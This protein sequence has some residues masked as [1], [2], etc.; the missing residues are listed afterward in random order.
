[1]T[2]QGNNPA[3]S[4]PA[5]ASFVNS[6]YPTSFNG[7]SVSIGGP[8]AYLYCLSTGQLNVISPGN[9]PPG[10]TQVVVTNNGVASEP[11]TVSV[12]P[13][14]PAF[15]LWPGGYAVARDQNFQLRVKAGKFSG[16][17]TTPAT[18][19]TIKK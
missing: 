17:M 6:S 15:F 19:L 1:M 9:L 7:V 16:V 11:A 4:Q 14:A 10:N 8:P 12:Q 2:I 13:F 18:M 5:I 3:N